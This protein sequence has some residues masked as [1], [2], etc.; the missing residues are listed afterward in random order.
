[1]RFLVSLIFGVLTSPAAQAAEHATAVPGLAW[2]A[3]FALLLL[4]IAVLP[5]IAP[6]FWH[7]RMG[8]VAL[9]WT[10]AL[11]GP[12]AMAHGMPSAAAEV[13]HAMLT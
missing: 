1:M 2:G 7:H 8:L 9:G 12:L 10:L 3:P 5:L 11:V 13:W 6:R 4:S